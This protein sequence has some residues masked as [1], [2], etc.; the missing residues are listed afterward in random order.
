MIT[1]IRIPTISLKQTFSPLTFLK[2]STLYLLMI[3]RR[4]LEQFREPLIELAYQ[5]ASSNPALF[6]STV[7]CLH[8]CSLAEI[9][10]YLS[11]TR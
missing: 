8:L 3:L 1:S 4:N 7:G 11:L 2:I 10:L 6:L 9:L 5:E